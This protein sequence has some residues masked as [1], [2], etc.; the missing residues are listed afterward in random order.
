VHTHT[1][2]HSPEHRAREAAAAAVE[3]AAAM[4]QQ[5]EQQG[6]APDSAEL[7]AKRADYYSKWDKFA[8]E[9]VKEAEKED[10]KLAEEAARQ[11]GIDKSA[12]KSEAEKK[13]M[14]K[15]EALKAAKK[16]W[17]DK[18]MSEAAAKAII[19]EDHDGAEHV[20][21]EALLGSKRVVHFKN[22]KNSTY[23]IPTGLNMRLVKVFIEDCENCT[24]EIGA[25]TI[26]QHVEISHCTGCEIVV[27]APQSILQID[28]CK[29]LNVHY[30]QN[31][32][33]HKEHKVFHAG[34][35]TSTIHVFPESGGAD[36]HSHDVDYIELGAREMNERTKEEHQ[37]ITHW[38]NGRLVT[39]EV[40]R[41]KGNMPLTRKQIE[42]AE[43]LGDGDGLQTDER[44]AEL[45]KVGGNEAFSEA[46]YAQA[47]IF[48]TEGIE[49]APLDSKLRPV[50]Y[51]NRSFA[52]MK[53]GRLPEALSDAENAV[54]ADASYCKGHFRKGLALHALKR[55]HEA[56]RALTTA[57][58]LEPKNQQIKQALGF[59]ELRA[60]QS[61]MCA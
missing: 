49:L 58:D 38:Q 17:D 55:Y 10:E 16:L 36:K 9:S 35:S 6:G 15:R 50:L 33:D 32:F 40:F 7:A 37:F 39:E 30:E 4:T 21:D 13:D 24:F 8:A 2:L 11:L 26:S 41:S 23:R 19:G 47:A 42:E 28:L 18:K 44:A 5:Q 43:R 3:I 25:I 61:G 51:A 34:V 53:L 45:K 1:R 48:Y 20:V 27:K 57:L 12:P 22:S 31:V 54:E 29:D 52:H 14:E 60:R 46:N 56:C 59:A